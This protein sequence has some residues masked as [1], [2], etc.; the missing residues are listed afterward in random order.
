MVGISGL[1][2][3]TERVVGISGEEDPAAHGCPDGADAGV[4]YLAAA[5]G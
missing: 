2:D 3:D 1:K 5:E 4:Q